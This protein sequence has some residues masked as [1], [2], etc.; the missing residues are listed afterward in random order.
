[1]RNP[2]SRIPTLPI[3]QSLTDKSP[4]PQSPNPQL[5]KRSLNAK[6]LLVFRAKGRSEENSRVKELAHVPR[7]DDL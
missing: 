2:D 4:N 7:K 5:R 3:S 6:L 1:V